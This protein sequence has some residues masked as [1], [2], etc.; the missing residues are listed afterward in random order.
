MITQFGGDVGGV[1]ADESDLYVQTVTTEGGNYSFKDIPDGSYQIHV[2]K[3]T[4]DLPR[5][6][7][8]ASDALAALKIGVGVTQDATP[9]QLIAADVNQNGKVNS[10][11]ALAILK[12]AVGHQDAV[13]NKFVFIDQAADLQDLTARKVNYQTGITLETLESE[14]YGQ[15]FIGIL[16][17]DVN[18]NYVD[19]V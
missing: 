13:E 8:K 18:G 14:L 3:D 1:S 19:F 10:A 6:A 7:I 2:S 9:H 17:G 15:D 4:I 5:G 12:I 11:D 16:L